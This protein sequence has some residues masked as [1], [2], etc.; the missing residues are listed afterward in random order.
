MSPLPEAAL[1]ISV[2]SSFKCMS[3]KGLEAFDFENIVQGFSFYLQIAL[4]KNN[5]VWQASTG[6]SLP[7]VV[8]WGR[9]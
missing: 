5:L 3:R 6:S 7:H 1:T 9:G 8:L 2:T 4:L